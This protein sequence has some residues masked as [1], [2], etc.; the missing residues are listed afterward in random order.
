MRRNVPKGV[1]PVRRTL[2]GGEIRI[3]WYHRATGQRLKAEP[4]SAAWLAEIADLDAKVSGAGSKATA[5]FADLWR[6]YTTSQKW[7]D[8]RPR[9]RSDYQAVRD[10]LGPAADRMVLRRVTSEQIIRLQDKAANESGRRFGNY[11]LQV[12]RLVIGWG[13]PRGWLG[14]GKQPGD[15]PAAAVQSIKRPKHARKVN[16]AWSDD[17]VKAFAEAAPFQILV[18]FALGL[19][20]GMRQGDAITVTWSALKT[21][22]LEWIASKNGEEC[23]APVT[24]AFRDILIGAKIRRGKALQIAV[25]SDGQPWTESGFR[26]SF[27]KLV[28]KLV[29]EGKMQP[30]CTFHGLRSTVVTSARD[31]GESDFRAAAAIGDRSTDMAA[32]YGADADRMAAQRDVLEAVQKRF[33]NI[34]LENVLENGPKTPKGTKRGNP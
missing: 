3:Y 2:A 34:S 32:L 1:K 25:N 16:R 15:N 18:P 27:F 12:V 28:R 5:T 20:A 6:D 7:R 10:W 17:E 21:G 13:I 31:T 9:T 23:K 8:L 14:E 26:A 22:Q 19:F 29:E 4:H 33:G 30:G 11:V 24:G